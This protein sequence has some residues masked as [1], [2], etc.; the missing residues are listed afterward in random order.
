M[1]NDDVQ[2]VNLNKSPRPKSNTAKRIEQTVFFKPKV[3]QTAVITKQ[4]IRQTLDPALFAVKDV[5]CRDNGENTD[6]AEI[7][8]VYQNT[9]GL[10]TKIDDF[11]VSVCDTE[12]DIIILTETW[13]ND[14][15]CSPQL[16]GTNYT[17]YRNDR[18]PESTGK[19]RGGGVLIAVS[20]RLS[21]S[22]I[23]V[24]V[25]CE[26]E[27]LWV[28][29]DGG[30]RT[31]CLGTVYLP[32]DVS[33]SISAIEKHIDSALAVSKNLQP[34]DFHLIF[35][36]FNQPGLSWKCSPSGKLYV[37]P[38]YSTSTT[39]GSALVDGM[40]VLNM[41]QINPVSN[42]YG[43]TLDLVFANGNAIGYCV[44]TEAAE[45]LTNADEHH[46]PLLANLRCPSLVKFNDLVDGRAFDFYRA[47]FPGLNLALQRI[48]WS[49][50]DV[51]DVDEAVHLFNQTLTSLFCTYVPKPKEKHKPPWS[52]HRLRV[53]KRKRATALKRYSR[54]R[55]VSTKLD[56]TSAS[57]RY[58]NYNRELYSIYV[59]RK[60]YDL[61]RNPKKFW[62]FVNEKRKESGLPA[63]M[64]LGE[65]SSSRLEDTCGLFAHQFSSVFGDCDVTTEDI[66]DAIKLVPEN[67]CHIRIFYVIP[68]VNAAIR[69]E[70]SVSREGG[71]V[72][73]RARLP[74]NARGFWRT[75]FFWSWLTDDQETLT[76]DV[77]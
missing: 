46:P 1:S 73:T 52:N 43:R 30:C 55:N 16:F 9:R 58:R 40:T 17:V 74:G 44:I 15:I 26:V 66:E 67:L 72:L 69:V 4:D 62:S 36:D 57:S 61:R 6:T 71:N 28:N 68:P 59:K 50:L 38:V 65:Q 35:G 22:R 12:F 56:F 34:P 51:D 24:E 5:R 45:P 60:Q 13:L 7:S 10:R 8:I 41:E 49:I 47:D 25:Q 63:K 3:A 27:Q 14:Q 32:P 21:S 64:F 48:D 11:Y 37:D 75:A 20:N 18:D 76:L 39:A 33:S 29:I 54:S 77:V 23:S 19:K 53:L 31:I 70:R 2:S 42:V